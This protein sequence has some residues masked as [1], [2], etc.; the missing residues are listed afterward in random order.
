MESQERR[1]DLWLELTR[2]GRTANDHPNRAV[3]LVHIGI[4]LEP[5]VVFSSPTH[6]TER[7]GAVVAGSGVDACEVDHESDSIGSSGLLARLRLSQV[8]SI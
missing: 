1:H 3:G 6:V 5:W 7:G 4:S 8:S 2:D